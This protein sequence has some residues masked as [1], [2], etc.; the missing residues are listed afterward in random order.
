MVDQDYP[1]P[2]GMQRHTFQ[3]AIFD[4]PFRYQPIKI[5]GKGTY[6]TVISCNNT[7]TGVQCA[8]K[9]L[10]FIDEVVSHL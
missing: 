9:K 8:I 2:V 3:G 5:I 1:V 4:L 10:F 7:Q 6:G